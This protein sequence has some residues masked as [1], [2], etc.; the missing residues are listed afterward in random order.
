[1]MGYLAHAIA[2]P[3]ARLW[4]AASGQ[5][6]RHLPTPTDSPI[7]HAAGADS[8]RILLLGAGIAVGY[9]VVSH[10][11]ALGGHLARELSA[12]TGRGAS[13]DIV[14]GPDIS[15]ATAWARLDSV[16]LARFDALVLTLGG[17]EGITLMPVTLWR[18]QLDEF[19]TKLHA[20]APASLGIFLVEIGMPLIG[21]MPRGVRSRVRRSILDLNNQIRHACEQWPSTFFVAFD[22]EEGDLAGLT[23]RHTYRDWAE[24]IAPQVAH[25]LGEETRTRGEAAVDEESRQ[26]SVDSLDLDLAPNAELDLI[27]ENARDLFGA[28]GASVT[29]IDRDLQ[30][31]KA[32]I[33]LPRDPVPRSA[34]ICNLTIQRAGVFVVEDTTTDPRF[35]DSVWADGERIR[36]YAGYPVESPGG[37]RV[38]ALAVVDS[39]PRGFSDTDATLLRQLALRVQSVLWGTR[40]TR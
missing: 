28:S 20:A 22:P 36:F 8:D 19:L 17:L 31:T 7:V 12:R 2:N 4:L 14:S 10:D 3:V 15:P 37:Q 33:G 30:V 21:G 29:F 1:M 38:G 11:L 5:S 13:V 27:I 18:R 35:A 25:V 26:Q 24:L 16:D 39:Q 40:P 34:S 6:W 23:G 32:A 9:G